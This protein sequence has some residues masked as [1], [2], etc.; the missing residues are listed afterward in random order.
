MPIELELTGDLETIQSL[1]DNL[2]KALVGMLD[3]VMQTIMFS[4][5]DEVP[6][7][8]GNLKA[9]HMIDEPS[10]L[11]RRLYPDESRAPYAEQVILGSGPHEIVPVNAQALYWP[12]ADHPV[13]RVHHPGTK[14]N[15]YL[16]RAVAAADTETTM[17]N[18]IELVLGGL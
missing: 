17:N 16:E 6:I 18:Y 4:V 12:G 15:P 2:T 9:S 3:D 1:E 10:P 14:P 5:H 13:R 8:T 7:R 11:E